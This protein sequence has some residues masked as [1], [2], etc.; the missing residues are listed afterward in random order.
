MRGLEGGHLP[1]DF[2]SWGGD[3]LIIVIWVWGVCTESVHF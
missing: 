3:A 1:W 2:V